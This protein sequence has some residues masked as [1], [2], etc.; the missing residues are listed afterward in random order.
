LIKGV[1]LAV[2]FGVI[3]TLPVALW[4]Y[5]HNY[6]PYGTY[7]GVTNSAGADTTANILQSLRKIMY[8][9][10]PYRPISESGLVEPVVILGLTIAALLVINKLH[11]WLNWAREFLR[12]ALVSMLVLTFVYFTSSI[13]NIQTGDHKTLF[14]DRYFVIILVP[15]LALI[16]ITFD[17]LILPHLHLR[18]EQIQFGMVILFLLWS[19]YP[20]Y[21]IYKYVSVSLV[22]GESGYNEYNTRAFHESETLAKVKILLENEPDA[23]LYSNIAPAVWFITR[24]TMTLP[25]AQDV[26]RTKDGI[27]AEFAGWPYDKPGYYVWFEPDPFELFMPLDDLYLVADMEVV[28]KTADGMIVRVWARKGQ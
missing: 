11:N 15:I 25:P 18:T 17:R 26:K 23:R 5:L 22:E 27:K 19:C 21:K 3:S 20:V 28:E 7:W 9:F 6:L 12:P 10:V 1:P 24:H 13:L 8:W 2:L 14:S 16:F 4:V